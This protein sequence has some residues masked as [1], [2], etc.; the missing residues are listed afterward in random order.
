MPIQFN[1][2]T[3]ISDGY[4]AAVLYRSLEVVHALWGGEACIV[5]ATGFRVQPLMEGLGGVQHS[6]ILPV[7]HQLNYVHT[8]QL[9]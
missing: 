1:L 8:P 4:L 9:P 3:P 2:T 7:H 6:V 5:A